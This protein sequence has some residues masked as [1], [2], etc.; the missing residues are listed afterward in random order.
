LSLKDSAEEV[1]PKLQAEY[2]AIVGWLMYLFQWTRLDLGVTVTFLSRCLHKPGIKPLQTAK[3][4]LRY[5]Q[6]TKTMGI[7][8]I[9][10][11][12]RLRVRGHDLNVLH[13]LSDSDSDFAGCKDAAKST[14]GCIVL[15]NCGPVAYHS[16]RQTT[17]APHTA[18]AETIAL[19]K[20]VAE[21]QHLRALLFDL[22]A[23]QLQGTPI[24]STIVWVDNTAALAVAT[25]ND[26]TYATVKHVTVKVRFLQERVKHKIVRLTCRHSQ[27]YLRY[28]DQAI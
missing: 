23:V 3:H 27:E 10:D 11:I 18:M 20:L 26:F 16:G 8:Y 4:T 1:D 21:I 25:G 22:Q 9:R 19:A 17:T 12:D 28:D 7:R 6:D 13:G 14:S 2:C 15:L 24:R 5:L